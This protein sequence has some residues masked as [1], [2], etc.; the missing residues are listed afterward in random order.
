[1]NYQNYSAAEKILLPQHKKI[2]LVGGCFDILHFGHIH[3]L[4][5]AKE[6]GDY[7]I[8]ALEP[9]E[10]IAQYKKRLPVH[11]QHERMHN[12]L[13][14]RD[15]DHVLLLPL[16]QGFDDYLA[17]VQAVAP[18]SIAVTSNDPQMHNKQKQAETIHAQLVVV[19]PRIE[20]FSSSFIYH[21]QP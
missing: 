4:Q 18:H 3:F 6:L 9:D 13:A 15:V 5:K 21:Q 20:P 11:N 1:M 19:T 16:L 8:V 17:L 2:I 7:L 12:L 14:L 10:S